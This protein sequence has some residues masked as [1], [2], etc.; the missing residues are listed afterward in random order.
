MLPNKWQVILLKIKYAYMPIVNVYTGSVFGFEAFLRGY[1][2]F[3]FSS[4]KEFFDAAYKEK[5]LYEV[6]LGLRKIAIEDFLSIPHSKNYKL[7]FNLDTRVFEMEDYGVNNTKILL[8]KYNLDTDMFCFEVSEQ[9]ELDLLIK[10]E[11]LLNTYK[12]SGLQV[13][14][15]NFSVTLSATKILHNAVPQY[16]KVDA[17]YLEKIYN[18]GK[19]REAIVNVFSLASSYNI[20]VIA[21]EVEEESQVMLCKELGC[22]LVEGFLIQEPL[23]DPNGFKTKYEII[24]NI[25]S[26]HKSL[27]KDF[28]DKSIL[29]SNIEYIQPII[30]TQDVI[31]AFNY[32]VKNSDVSFMPV[33]DRNHI[34]LGIIKEKMLKNYAYAM[35]GKDVL[36]N[37]SKDKKLR[38]FVSST[39]VSDVNTR[40][41]KLLDLFFQNNDVDGIIIT[42]NSFYVGFLSAKTLLKILYERGSE[43]AN[44]FSYLTNLPSFRP[45]QEYVESVI[46][47]DEESAI[48]VYL[49]LSN[50][51][52]FNSTYG[53]TIGD[54]AIRL[55]GEVLKG[56][57][58][59]REHFVGHLG[60]NDFFIGIKNMDFAQVLLIIQKISS[61]FYNQSMKF[62]TSSEQQHG[63]FYYKD[64]NG[65]D[66][67]YEL[68]SVCAAILEM[69]PKSKKIKDSKLIE[70]AAG[71]KES[72]KSSANKISSLTYYGE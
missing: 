41:E 50:F 38:D 33:L 14:I 13:A 57:S 24:E 56:Q 53:F 72:A 69:F 35:Y 12:Q 8:N 22:D 21:T 58:I 34:P 42:D 9:K 37:I 40:V 7:F 48:F 61:D 19:I 45:T 54:S 43:A 20:K 18:E 25:N 26:V 2:P 6:D 29:L 47:G 71:L 1:E 16:L 5:V 70:L 11:D 32:F 31:D 28:T 59:L 44:K 64:Q 49:E 3:G 52:E 51:K 23:V 4:V 15:D 30:I 67:K 39:P 68:M 65:L 36:S 63:Y 66:N 27:Y 60:G 10:A 62:Y 17:A 55:L 46:T